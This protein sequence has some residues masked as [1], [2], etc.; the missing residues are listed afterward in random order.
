MVQHGKRGIWFLLFFSPGEL[1]ISFIQCW[2]SSDF[3]IMISSGLGGNRVKP[4][5]ASTSELFLECTESFLQSEDKNS[6]LL[7]TLQDSQ[8][9][10]ERWGWNR[11][12]F[13]IIYFEWSEKS[14]LKK[15]TFSE[16]YISQ[17]T[18]V[19]NSQTFPLPSLLKLLFTS[20][21][22]SKSLCFPWRK[23]LVLFCFYKPMPIN[24]SL[25]FF[26]FFNETNSKILLTK[27]A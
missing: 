23:L 3:Q 12:L 15:A 24:I 19:P 16:M 8:E 5:Q 11:F 25:F 6:F 14:S 1:T 27:P 26:F 4:A 21:L 9:S 18:P 13:C 2:N 22:F 10:L 20:W 17:Q 7:L